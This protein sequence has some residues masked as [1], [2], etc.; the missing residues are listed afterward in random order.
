MNNQDYYDQLAPV[1]DSLYQSAYSQHENE[2]VAQIARRLWRSPGL[3]V[4]CGTGLGFELLGQP[5]GYTGVD[6]SSQM[7]ALARRKHPT[8]QFETADVNALPFEDNSFSS[9]FMF[10]GVWSHLI[11]PIRAWNEIQRVTRRGAPVLLMG[12]NR[13]A[14]W[15]VRDGFFPVGQYAAR[16]DGTAG[17]A[18][19]NYLN[20]RSLIGGHF[21]GLSFGG[22]WCEIAALWP[23]DRWLCRRWPRRAHSWIWTGVNAQDL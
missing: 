16:Y 15:R 13:M 18:Y 7:T 4:G 8:A 3:D 12:L 17:A 2:F 14:L 9:L 6:I 11:D 23:L 20:D 1:Y 22:G 21:D 5:A 19:V 10:F